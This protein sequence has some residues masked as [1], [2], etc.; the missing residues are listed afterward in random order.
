LAAM[1]DLEG[2]VA[3]VTG[4]GRGIGAAAAR[5]LA[6]HGAAVVVAARTL[7]QVE[8]VAA[9]LRGDGFEALAFGCDVADRSE[10]DDLTLA[11]RREMGPVDILVNNAGTASSNPLKRLTLEEW[12][13]VLAV[14]V[15]GTFLL[16]K[17]LMPDMLDAGWGRVVNVASLAGLIGAKYMSAY[18]AS[19]HA[20]VGFTRAVAAEVAGTGVT[21]NAVCPGFVDTV[22]TDEVV[23]RIVQR[24]GR[25]REEALRSLLDQAGQARLISSEEVAEA[26]VRLCLEGSASANGEAIVL[27]GKD[28]W[29]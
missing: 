3:L 26:V 17:A 13:R 7:E 9:S 23:T 1:D 16:T 11:V 24:T 6:G 2:R 10:I 19:K 22:L 15:T 29:V 5:S 12:N 4:G 27:D 18:T 8:E 25:S 20:A 21:A 28:G 14:N